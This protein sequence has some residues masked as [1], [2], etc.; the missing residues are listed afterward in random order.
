MAAAFVIDMG[1]PEMDALWK[2]LLAKY[3]AGTL[4]GD[5]RQLLKKLQ[6]TLHLL[7]A[8]PRRPGLAS[9]EIDALTRR[10][11]VKVWQ[12]YLENRKPAAGRLFWIYGPAKGVITIVGLEDHPE[13]KKVS[14]YASVK[15]SRPRS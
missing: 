3:S 1:V 8:N 4:S 2:D 5:D 14:G 7:A 10:F 6:K 13:S 11:G 9:H 12:S 15:L